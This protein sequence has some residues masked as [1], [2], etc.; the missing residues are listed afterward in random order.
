MTK[1]AKKWN[2]KPTTKQRMKRRAVRP[3]RYCRVDMTKRA[4]ILNR[5]PAAAK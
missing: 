5:I 1:Q 2:C 4:E 3:Q